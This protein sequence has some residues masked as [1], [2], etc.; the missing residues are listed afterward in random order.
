MVLNDFLLETA[1]GRASLTNAKDNK[2]NSGPRFQL[3]ELAPIEIQGPKYCGL[4]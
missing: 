1:H 4:E 2:L 3:I